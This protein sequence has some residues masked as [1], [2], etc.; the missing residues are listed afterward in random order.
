[1]IFEKG[2]IR[3][4]EGISSVFLQTSSRVKYRKDNQ[5]EKNFQAQEIFNLSWNPQT[6]IQKR[7]FTLNK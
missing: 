2:K 7:H 4:A 3:W 6:L 5:F 1:M